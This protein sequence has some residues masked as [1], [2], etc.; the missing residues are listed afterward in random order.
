MPGKANVSFALGQASGLRYGEDDYLALNL[1]TAVLGSGFFSARLLDVVRT[2]EG[3]TYGITANLGAD[4]YTD[5]VWMIQAGFAPEL[6]EKGTESVRRE[7]RRFCTDGVTAEELATF[8]VTLAGSYK[9][10]L[11]TTEE[12]AGTVLGAVE[13]G[14]G[15]EWVDDYLVRMQTLT[16]EDVNAAIRKHLNPDRMVMIR[17]GTMSPAP[18]HK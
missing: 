10:T 2:R 12:L 1:G 16:L 9:V 3:L 14:L 5:G 17:A 18:D 8:K 7:L 11:S 6:L 15:P 13:R 4:T